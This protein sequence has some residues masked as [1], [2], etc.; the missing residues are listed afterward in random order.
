MPQ[1]PDHLPSETPKEP[2]P[3]RHVSST[4][5]KIAGGLGVIVVAGGVAAAVWGDRV[6]NNQI[7]PRVETEIKKTIGRPVE[8]GDF[9]G[10][11]LWGV[12]LGQTTLPPI[13]TDASSA[14]VDEIIITVDLL[15]LIFQQTIQ[16]DIRLVRPEVNLVQ[17]EDGKWLELSLPEPTEEES[18]FNVELQSIEVQEA[19]LIA[20]TVLQDPAALVPREPVQLRGVDVTADFRGADSQ[21]VAFDVAGAIA[22]G[23]FEIQGE[24]DLAKRAVNSLVRLQEVPVAGANLLLPSQIGLTSGTLSTH[25]T[26]ALALT[27]ENTLDLDAVDLQ[28]T[29]R[30]REGEVQV[31]QLAAPITDIRSQLR[32]QGQKVTLEET[33][34][35]LEEVTLV[36]DGEVDLQT[37]YNL[38]AQIPE[39]AIADVQTLAAIALP[40]EAD[41]LF[42]LDTQ[43]TG[44]LTAPQVQGRLANLQPVR[45]DR[46]G[47]STVAA[48]FAATLS[49]FDLTELQ[50]IPEN[51]GVVSAQGNA[52]LADLANPSFQLTAQVDLPVDAYA[53]T[54]GL[55]LPAE[56][57]IGSLTADVT[58]EGNLQAQTAFAQW[59]LSDSSFPGTG[60]ITLA[61]QT[62]ALENTRLQV[63]DGTVTAEALAALENGDWQATIATV[64]IPVE[65]F[66]RRAAGRLSA[67]LE[68]AGN[69]YEFDLATLKA[70]GTAAIA[71]A[72]V[73]LTE[74]S[75]PLLKQGDWTTA[76]EWQGDRVAIANF[77]APG[78]QA[79]GTIGIDFNQSIPI[80]AIALNLALREF[81]LQP[82]NSLAPANVRD[83]AQLAGLTSFEG[84][85]AGTLETLEISGDARLDGLAINQIAFEPLAGPIAFSLQEG[86]R[87]DLRGP[88]D[89]I[90]LVVDNEP[91]PVSFTVRNGEFLATGSGK[92]R[93]LFVD[94]TD[95]PLAQLEIRPADAYG[96]GSVTGVVNASLNADLR[97]FRNPL[98]SGN[99]TVDQ[100]G[101]SPI[102]ATQ[103]SASFRY[104]DAVAILEQGELLL[105]NSRYSLAGQATLQPDIQYEGELTIDEGNIE[106][107]IAV[108]QAVDLSALG[109]GNTAP[110]TG[111]AA[112]L[113]TTPMG[114]PAGSFLAQLED[115]LTFL[116]VHSDA[117][118]AEGSPA[119]PPLDTLSGKFTGAIAVAGRA[120]AIADL[121]ADFNL[122]GERWQWGP[123]SPPNEFLISGNVQQT[124]LTLDPVLIKAGDTIVNLTGSGSLDRLQGE[125]LV[126]NLPVGLVE[127]LYPLPV[128]MVGSL[129]AVTQLSGSVSNPV[130]R[131]EILVANS[132]IN[133]QP[134]HRVGGNF[135]YRDANLEFDGA[136]AI[137]PNEEPITLT[138]RIPYA[139]PFMTV[140]PPSDLINAQM[141]VPSDSFD[142]INPLSE[143][144]VRWESGSGEIVV[145]AGGTLAAPA[146]AG[147]AR[148]SE[149]VVSS[150]QLD[151]P[152][153]D[154]NGEVQFN[155]ERVGI[156]QLQVNLGDGSLEVSGQLPILPTGQSLLA[157]KQAKPQSAPQPSTGRDGLI[158][159][160]GDL[161]LNYNGLLEAVL[162]G[163]VLVTGAV[164]EPTVGGRIGIDDGRVKANELL[165]QAGSLQ[166]P[167]DEELAAINP[168]R[169]EYLGI[170]PRTLHVDET[171]QG[172]QERV[173][174]EDFVVT[175]SDRLVVAGQPFYN[176]AA[177]GGITLNGP[178]SDLQPS[179]TIKLQSGWIN[180]LST[181]F[182]LAPDAPNTAQFIPE[183]GLDPY[184]D[185]VLT[186]R[187]Q[188]TNYTPTPA[189]SDS[190][191]GS[192]IADTDVASIGEVEYINV[193]AMAEGYA[194]E[195]S[196]SLTLNSRPPR[197]QDE[198]LALLSSSIVGG[199][200][201]ATFTQFAEFVGVGSIAGFGGDL[202]NT[203]G[204][205]S[206]SVFPTTDTASDSNNSISIGVEA[207][208][209]IS[210]SIGV[211]VLEILDSGNPPQ[212]GA[213]YQFTEE[214]RLRGTSNLDDSEV[215]LE[216][217][218]DF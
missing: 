130:A 204:L 191:S 138:G 117:T 59:Q 90:E 25:L 52:D 126:D 144:Q 121:T 217:R 207:S 112:D 113:E 211:N 8:I 95:F 50:I 162:E 26:A 71:D 60:E 49:A 175:L 73:R 137:A 21:Q 195:L 128:R 89:R 188:D 78:I 120:P 53:T 190:F 93:Q 171:S 214:L 37:G 72:Q 203:L 172:W 132:R 157:A 127:A 100:P 174:L 6:I 23:R 65:Q 56:T 32:F 92:D 115:Y 122:Q 155:L 192:E 183:D 11:Q 51:G 147:V 111:T 161:P 14:T 209:A 69:L 194:S 99:L 34:L 178:L 125:V 76:F 218:T 170:D 142:L 153:T 200:S 173:T 184:L 134:L 30:L 12:R 102:E 40:I 36:A 55:T 43:V 198:L 116:D 196:D 82:L 75:T 28:G 143:N 199:L 38:K 176:V 135:S 149:G 9:A 10:F 119:I 66:T 77:T 167:T 42:Q 160:L 27:A 197:S 158:I 24:G 84:Q 45:V 47:L 16:P 41:G 64:Q 86:G 79:D 151:K 129:D 4:L 165:R 159:A 118:I 154:I 206:F 57:V 19:Q 54:Y 108:L 18:L 74:T 193:R 145:Q 104:A 105:G 139:L 179:G 31:S 58:A 156:Q 1:L 107:L 15:P 186:A 181:Q 148:I 3:S 146:I 101:L 2:H 213:E 131:G 180:L 97:N 123:Y 35:R 33:G 182:R 150:E 106:D 166:L 81:D 98:A 7:L 48:D 114:L 109:L 189:S 87:L 208:F 168:Y 44:E 212:L 124:T 177:S 63:A 13:A 187:V 39:I 103:I 80:G 88:R 20:S 62:V 133:E 202:A 110:P 205:R 46:V 201:A 164:L 85:L 67:D 22:S 136:A 163:E 96:F 29:A 68:A 152:L 70:R 17:A 140:Q 83:Y 61:D 169:A 185:V 141:I 94:I 5:L 216:Y 91:W 215:R 210:D